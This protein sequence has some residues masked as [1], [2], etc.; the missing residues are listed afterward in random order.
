MTDHMRYDIAI[1]GASIS[2]CARPRSYLVARV[3]RWR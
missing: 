3:L 1:V 2:G